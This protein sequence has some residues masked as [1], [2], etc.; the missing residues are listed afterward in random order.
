MFR[1]TLIETLPTEFNP[2][3]QDAQESF[4]QDKILDPRFS[5]PV[6]EKYPELPQASKMKTFATIVND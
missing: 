1:F 5:T 2:S 3:S 4:L 6:S